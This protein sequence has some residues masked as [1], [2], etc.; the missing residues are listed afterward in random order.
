MHNPKPWYTIVGP[1]GDV[2]RS[3]RVRLARN[4]S[5]L[6]FT[7]RLNTQGKHLM[8]QTVREAA[9]ELTQLNYVDMAQLPR[10]QATAMAEKRL[11]SA[12][13]AAQDPGTALLTQDDERV[14]LMLCEEDHLRL[15]ALSPGLALEETH[16]IANEID[17]I[18][19][20]K[21]NFAFH[22][23][24]GYL[25]QCPTNLGTG[26]RASVMLHLPA[27]TLTARYTASLPTCPKSG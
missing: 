17:T 13:F 3:T 9:Q 16:A 6:P 25:T 23:T 14:V 11:I 5:N 18:L 15:Q 12:Q 27:L 21:L 26:M 4:L 1:E 7:T 22:D 8:V 24:L 19:S 20:R 2:V 10:L